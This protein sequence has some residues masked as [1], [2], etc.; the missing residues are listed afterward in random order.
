LVIVLKKFYG[1]GVCSKESQG[2]LIGCE[3]TYWDSGIVLEY[4]DAVLKEKI[5]GNTEIAAV[6][7]VGGRLQQAVG[8]S[9]AFAEPSRAG[10]FFNASSERSVVK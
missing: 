4:G 6:Q 7:K 2:P 8:R 3:V 5:A 1:S 9:E 10:F